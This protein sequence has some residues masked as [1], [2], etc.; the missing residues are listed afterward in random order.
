MTGTAGGSFRIRRSPGWRETD[1]ARRIHPISRGVSM[2]DDVPLI[3]DPVP[4]NQI[5]PGATRSSAPHDHREE[6]L[7]MNKQEL[8]AEL[9]DSAGMSK[10]DAARFVGHVFGHITD[11]LSRGEEVRL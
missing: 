5:M 2:T 1:D 8:A 6:T 3:C 7:I 4:C 9:S 10:A 11:A